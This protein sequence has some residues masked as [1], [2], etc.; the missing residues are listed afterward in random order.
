[1]CASVCVCE[2]VIETRPTIRLHMQQSWPTHYNLHIA[3]M[4]TTT[5]QATHTSIEWTHSFRF[6]RWVFCG[7]WLVRDVFAFC[8][9]VW[10]FRMPIIGR[11]LHVSYCNNGNNIYGTSNSNYVYET[12]ELNTRD[13]KPEKKYNNLIHKD[14]HTHTNNINLKVGFSR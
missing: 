9:S 3:C 6:S 10:V 1:M 12:H 14:T 8:V 11:L 2:F 5:P 13:R 4:L 7:W